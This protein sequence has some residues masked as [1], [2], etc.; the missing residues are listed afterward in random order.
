MAGGLGRLLDVSWGFFGSLLGDLE[1]SRGI[2]GSVW[3]GLG[4]SWAV[5]GRSWAALGPLLAALEA[6]LASQDAPS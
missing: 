1:G 2:L 5:L 6:L 3:D 4:P